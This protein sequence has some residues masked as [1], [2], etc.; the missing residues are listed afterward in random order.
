MS[1]QVIKEKTRINRLL[2]YLDI[3]LFW[4]FIWFSSDRYSDTRI[5]S[6]EF[7]IAG[8]IIAIYLYIEHNRNQQPEDKR[9]FKVISAKLFKISKHALIC[10]VLF[11][12][13]QIP[14]FAQNFTIT[15][16]VASMNQMLLLAATIYYFMFFGAFIAFI[17]GII[18]L[19]MFLNTIVN[20]EYKALRATVARSCIMNIISCLIT[21]IG[22]SLL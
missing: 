21:F 8:I 20:K 1:E 17:C 3:L 2:K 13:T 4:N 19:I 7:L 12:I 14:Y 10:S 22:S 9:D 18:G 5:V 16:Y 11:M 15:S 6:N